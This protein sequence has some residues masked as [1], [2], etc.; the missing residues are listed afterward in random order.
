MAEESEGEPHYAPIHR[1]AQACVSC[2]Q[3]LF[4]QIVVSANEVL[5]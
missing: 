3:V 2:R 5:R 4:L 1:V